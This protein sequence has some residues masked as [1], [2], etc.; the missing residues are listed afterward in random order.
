M[1]MAVANEMSGKALFDT[2]KLPQV[3]DDYEAFMGEKA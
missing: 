3:I 1:Y 2:P